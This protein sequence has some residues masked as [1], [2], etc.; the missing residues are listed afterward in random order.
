M[1]IFRVYDGYRD[2]FEQS[3]RHETLFAVVEAIIFECERA[4]SEHM[5]RVDKIDSM[6]FLSSPSVFARTTRTPEP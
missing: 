4:T 5:R 1:V 6:R 2:T 3:K